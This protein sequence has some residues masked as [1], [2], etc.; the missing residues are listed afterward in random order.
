[1]PP[2]VRVVLMLMPLTTSAVRLHA[3][4]ADGPDAVTQEVTKCLRLVRV[5]AS[6][7]NASSDSQPRT[8]SISEPA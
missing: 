3:R 6:R 7:R 4:S 1:V 5:A 2:A 8:Q